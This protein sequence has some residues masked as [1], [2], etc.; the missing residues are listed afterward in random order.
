MLT[1]DA[2]GKETQSDP[3]LVNVMQK[4]QA[5]LS[6]LIRD[7]MV[8]LRRSA[9]WIEVEIRNNVLFASGSA[10]VNQDALEP[11]GKIAAILREISNRIQVEGFTDN[12]PINTPVYPSNWE[13]SA[14]R[15]ANVVHVL[16][17]N[18]VRP[19][20]M[21]AIGYGEYQPIADNS[22]ETGR[23]QNRRVVL[24]IMGNVDARYPVDLKLNEANAAQPLTK[25]VE[26][27]PATGNAVATPKP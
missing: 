21:S 14:A 10:I 13:L 5:A 17:N 27:P 15:A 1:A 4:L 20:R 2:A 26:A 23:T 12:R 24:V 19:E 3:N 22:S 11:L 8:S 6:A 7:D 18:G 9:L 16:M 25:L